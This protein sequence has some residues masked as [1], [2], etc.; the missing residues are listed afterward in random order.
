MEGI[1]VAGQGLFSQENKESAKDKVQSV[2]WSK[3][4]NIDPVPNKGH[5]QRTQAPATQGIRSQDIIEASSTLNS[6]EVRFQNYQG[7]IRIDVD[8][9]I[10]PIGLIL[11]V[12]GLFI[13]G[14]GLI[15][16]LFW[17]LKY[18]ELKDELNRTFPAYLPPGQQQYG[19][20]QTAPPRQGQNQSQAPPPQQGTGTNSSEE[21]SPNGPPPEGS[22]SKEEK[23][24]SDND[25][26]GPEEYVEN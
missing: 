13:F 11:G 14:L 20:R 18:N 24:Q 17:F 3:G 1:R 21:Q 16:F 23:D 12:I 7:G 5:G 25:Y 15:L 26:K 22:Q 2:V 4:M 19:G 6:I 9:G 8:H 10:T